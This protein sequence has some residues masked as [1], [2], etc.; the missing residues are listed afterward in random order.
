MAE[1]MWNWG[2]SCSYFKC[3]FRLSCTNEITIPIPFKV[4]LWVEPVDGSPADCKATLV[5]AVF[6]DIVLLRCDSASQQ[7]QESNFS[8]FI[9]TLY[10]AF[11]SAFFRGCN[12][13]NPMRLGLF[14]QRWAK[15][16]TST[17]GGSWANY[18]RRFGM[19]VIGVSHGFYGFFTRTLGEPLPQVDG[20]TGAS[21]SWMFGHALQQCDGWTGGD[22]SGSGL[23]VSV[24]QCCWICKSFENRLP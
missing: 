10:S 6:E 11:L 14:C 20:V 5:H 9:N 13:V 15:D 23:W 2:R 21:G 8:V 18:L 17:F 4:L 7:Q 19:V 12:L 1:L 16:F 22:G 24:S 3:P